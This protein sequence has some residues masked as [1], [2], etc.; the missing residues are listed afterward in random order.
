MDFFQR[1]DDAHKRS[2]RLVFLFIFAVLGVIAA[3]YFVSVFVAVGTGG[4]G[5]SLWNPEVL[6]FAAG[7]T[8][9]VITCGSLFKI[10]K[11]SGGGNSV[12]LML[13]GRPLMP[14]SQNPT[15]RKILNVVEEMAIASGVPV[16][17]V[18]LLDGEEGINA[19]AAGRTTADSVIGVTKGCVEKLSRDELQGVV[20]HE[21]SHILNGD[22]KLNIRL[23]G[24]L[25]GILVLGIMG[26]W[27][28]RSVRYSGRG[29]RDGRAVLGILVVG[30]A[31]FLIGYI[32]VFFGNLIKAGV[33]RQR[34][35]LADSSAVQF[36]R[37]PA[38][39]AGALKKIGGF[40][41]GALVQNRHTEEASHM[42]FGAALRKRMMFSGMMATHPPLD[43]RIKAID[44]SFDGTFEPVSFDYRA[45]DGP[46]S[47]LAGGGAKIQ[48]PQGPQE[49]SA[50]P[51]QLL[52][53]VGTP[54]PEHVS[55]SAALLNSFPDAVRNATH[56][57]AGSRAVI[58]TVLLDS[59]PT[60]MEGQMN[61]LH[62]NAESAEYQFVW[63]LAQ[64]VALLGHKARLPLIDMCMPALRQMTPEQYQTFAAN[65]DVLIKADGKVDLFEYTL[66]K[67]LIRHLSSHFTRQRPVRVQFP[68]AKA[69][70]AEC[71]VL[72]S[73]LAYAGHE[74]VDEAAKA[75]DVAIR[76][77]NLGPLAKTLASKEQA[78][79]SAFDYALNRINASTGE[80]KRL[81][82]DA[83]AYCVAADG[84]V[85]M[86][87]A[88]LLRAIADSLDCPMPPFLS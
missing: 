76:R 29:R 61:H 25:H 81:V 8:L 7:G 13:G 46:V 32:G 35:Y 54:S 78:K 38:G 83:C 43:K 21:F 26:A 30:L 87:E 16:P 85:T 20:A 15:E 65:I 12:A 28:L 19:F 79:M 60:I 77:L 36:T 3:V 2:K 48:A 88:E 67:I 71:N 31:L 70:A 41:P 22:C 27:L 17:P 18:Y 47:Q 52:A 45:P 14:N 62:K 9:F 82:L 24:V 80:T 64:Q 58:Y 4:G 53:N 63:D 40:A 34:E 23:I 44:P 84:K 49:I 57:P 39:I 42:F 59:D 74:T 75:Y 10:S 5:A 51:N 72:I 37:N 6:L 66:Q 50:T 33:S 11:L 55:Y 86:E 73:V 56:E 68:S 69:L 1:Q